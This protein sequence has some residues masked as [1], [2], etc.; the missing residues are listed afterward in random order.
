MSIV[1]EM[2]GPR[3]TRLPPSPSHLDLA[4][5]H[6]DFRGTH[7]SLEMVCA[8]ACTFAFVVMKWESMPICAVYASAGWIHEN[9]CGGGVF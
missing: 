3:P 1:S 7:M 9:F 4:G 6:L 2:W 8:H 5:I